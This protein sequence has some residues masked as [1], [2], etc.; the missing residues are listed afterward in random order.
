MPDLSL[1]G[2]IITLKG[3]S[4]QDDCV[5]LKVVVEGGGGGGGEGGGGGGADTG[6]QGQ[7]T[8][9]RVFGHSWN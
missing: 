4:S 7:L 5:L 8:S 6:N 2:P 9:C 3:Q 1:P